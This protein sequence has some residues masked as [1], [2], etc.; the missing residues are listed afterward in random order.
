[1][2]S[3]G[4]I[5]QAVDKALS[6]ISRQLS[7]QCSIFYNRDKTVTATENEGSRLG[8]PFSYL[9]DYKDWCGGGDLNPYALR[10]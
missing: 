3:Q 5:L 7:Y 8:L 10:R 4:G 2:T 1:M 9:I 6:L